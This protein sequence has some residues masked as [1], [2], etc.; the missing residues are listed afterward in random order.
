MST[1]GDVSLP[2][3]RDVVFAPA[4]ASEVL[5]LGPQSGTSRQL[6]VVVV[7]ILVWRLPR[8]GGSRKVRFGPRSHTVFADPTGG[9]GCQPE[10]CGSVTQD[11]RPGSW[12]TACSAIRRVAAVAGASPVPRLRA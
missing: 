9:P 5:A 7:S 12:Y 10:K 6:G 3:C 2:T 11:I 8:A 4:R 1:T